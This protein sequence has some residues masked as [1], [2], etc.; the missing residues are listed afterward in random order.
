MDLKR[1]TRFPC[2]SDRGPIKVFVWARRGSPF[3]AAIATTCGGRC[4]SNLVNISIGKVTK[5]AENVS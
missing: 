3:A 1:A 2:D 4:R 5:C